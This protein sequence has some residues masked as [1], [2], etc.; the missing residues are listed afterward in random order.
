[1]TALSGSGKHGC[2]LK[3][4]VDSNAST[5][6]S[7]SDWSLSVVPVGCWSCH[8]YNGALN[9]VAFVHISVPQ[10]QNGAKFA[11]A[12]KGMHWKF[13]TG[14]S[15]E[16]SK[17]KGAVESHSEILRQVEVTWGFIYSSE[18]LLLYGDAFGQSIN[19]GLLGCSVNMFSE[20]LGCKELKLSISDVSHFSRKGLKWRGQL[21]SQAACMFNFLD[22]FHDTVGLLWRVKSFQ[23]GDFVCG[24]KLGS[25]RLGLQQS[26]GDTTLACL[27]FALFLPACHE[28]T[29]EAIAIS[30]DTDQ[31]ST[32]TKEKEKKSLYVPG[33]KTSMKRVEVSASMRNGLEDSP[34]RYGSSVEER[35]ERISASTTPHRTPSAWVWEAR[36]NVPLSQN[37]TLTLGRD[38]DLVLANPDGRVVWSTGTANKGVMGLRLLRTGNLPHRTRSLP[39]R[40]G[41]V[42]NPVS[43][44][45]DTY[46]LGGGP[47]AAVTFT[48][49]PETAEAPAY[50]YKLVLAAKG[51][52]SYTGVSFS[53]G[54]ARFNAALSLFRIATDGNLNSYTYDEMEYDAWEMTFSFFSGGGGCALPGRNVR[55]LPA[56]ARVAWMEQELPDSE[57]KLLQWE[58]GSFDYYRV[59]GVEHFLSRGNEGEGPMKVTGCRDAERIASARGSSTSRSLPGASWFLVPVIGT[60]AKGEN[61]VQ[62]SV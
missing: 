45:G 35:N 47:L 26:G 16:L 22:N 34:I 7:W 10:F 50:E 20:V 19:F 1:M 4:L 9:C 62:Y 51:E 28:F 56:A 30:S 39:R 15:D 13:L 3:F 31:Y 60:L 27:S 2:D 33:I 46:R 25:G 32:S 49:E 61:A 17:F 54:R 23:E 43:Y 59:E 18:A 41:N 58:F 8:S 40:P 55:G 24:G 44:L 29:T 42:G 36:R 12:R 48:A 53:L 11:G 57:E 14:D 52:G 6:L 21:L 5:N 37:A 38:G